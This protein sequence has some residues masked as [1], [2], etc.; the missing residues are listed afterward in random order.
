MNHKSVLSIAAFAFVAIVTLNWSE[1]S[2]Y[3]SP[4]YKLPDLEMVNVEPG[5]YNLTI[6]VPNVLERVYY[7]KPVKIKQPFQ[8]SQHEITVDQWNTCFKDG[9]CT[10]PAKRKKYQKGDHPVTRVS[11]ADA[12]D[13]TKWLSK[14]SGETY[15]LPTEEEWGYFANSGKGYTVDTIE[16][17][18]TDRQ[19]LKT[20]PL[21][22]FR[23]TRKVGSIDKN[24]WGITD[25]TGPVW[26]WTM[27]CRF[28]SDDANRKEWTIEQLRDPK[29]CPNRIVQGEERAHVPF[30]FDEVYTGGCGTG[31]PV[32]NIGFRVLKELS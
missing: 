17:L 4:P 7:T 12:M 16:K 24:D 20:T 3:W 11:W 1:I 10:H 22:L 23:K 26:E 25:L 19:M 6:L 14:K 29:L 5:A 32:D 31:S 21:S 2:R 15:R 18:I 30:F 13:F 28:P 8:I 27:T 9:G